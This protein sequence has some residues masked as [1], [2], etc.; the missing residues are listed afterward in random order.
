MLWIGATI[1]S[2]GANLGELF[3]KL[4]KAQSNSEAE[5]AKGKVLL[6]ALFE[7]LLSGLGILFFS[8]KKYGVKP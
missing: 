3:S 4:R 2:L 6:S 7:I 5:A 8:G 1:S